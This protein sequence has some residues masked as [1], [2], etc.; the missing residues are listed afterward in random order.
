MLD[1]LVR[2]RPEDDDVVHAVQKLRL[3]GLPQELRDLRLGLLPRDAPRPRLNQV[4]RADVRRHD[5]H[6]VAEIDRATLRVRQTTVI[7]D[8]QQHVEDVRMRLLDL[9]E[10]HDGVRPPP[11]RFRQLAPFLVADVSRRR[12]D[13]ARDRVLLHVLRHVEPHERP[14][15]VEQ[16][17][18]QRPRRLSL[19]D[20][21]WTEEDERAGRAIGILQPGA[22][23]PHGVR[24]RGQRFALPDHPL[25]QLL[26]QLEQSLLLRLEH[27]ADRNA[28][29]LRH[30]LR[31]VVVVH[32]FLQI[33]PLLLNL[34]EPFLERSDFLLDRRN[35]SVADLCRLLQIT[36]PRRLLGFGP[37]LLHLGFLRLDLLN[38]V[39]LR[40]PLRL[41]GVRFLAQL[42]QLL[43][44]L[45]A[46][47]LGRLVL[48]LRERGE[49]DLELRDLALD[50]VDL[51]R[52]RVDRNA[53]PRGGLVD[54]VDR[55]VGQEA[56]SDVAM[57]QR[58]S[59][60]EGV[61]R[62]ADTVVNL[63]LLFEAPQNRDRI[64]DRR[65][66]HVNGLEAT[67]ERRILLD[68]LAI[69]IERRRTDDV[70][71]ATRQR[72]L[73]HVGRVDRALGPT[74]ADQRMQLVDEDDVAALGRRDF[75]ENG[76]QP[77]LEFAAVLGAR[78]QR[79]DIQR[80][81]VLVLE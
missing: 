49:L 33:L 66:A 71:L 20:A 81:Q 37:Q 36:A 72:R 38:R 34:G 54:Q 74:R 39:L 48:L 32:L 3:E 40:L 58:R 24:H 41:H 7:E 21:R 79:P 29:P 46:P 28:G 5:Q 60:Y 6:G 17:L 19:A 76:F 45:V 11:N 26:F 22:R 68:V 9:V 73:Q 44:D 4:L 42:C 25:A 57:R 69:L 80:D 78:D 63:I 70:Q 14:L 61:V 50:F 8:L 2:Q 31:D 59:R 53:Q 18:G 55:L 23:A 12:A 15:V 62:D 51:L 77:L 67:L 27:L 64:F 10:Q 56:V 30:D 52:Q 75:L 43:L 47:F 35:P 13:H 16:E 65:L 1:I